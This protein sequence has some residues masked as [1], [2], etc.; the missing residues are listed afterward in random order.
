MKSELSK[1]IPPVRIDNVSKHF[2]KVTAVDKLTLDV[3]PG[4]VLAL[5]GANGSGKSTTFRLLL[6]IYQASSGEAYLLGTPSAKLNG[7]DFEQICYVSEGQKLPL[8]MTV[9]YFLGFCS[10]LYPSWDHDLCNRLVEAFGLPLQQK[11]KHLSRG[12]RMKA[13]VASTLPCRPKVL[14]LDEPFSG[15]DVE[16]R[17]Q[18]ASLLNRLAKD[19][20]LATVITTHDVE[21]VEPVA[22]RI[23]ILANG[24]L[25]INE[26]LDPF[27]GRHRRLT[28][29]GDSEVSLPKEFLERVK[30]TQ[31]LEGLQEFHTDQF[32]ASMESELNSAFPEALSVKAHPM[33]LREI[34][35]KKAVQL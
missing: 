23:A 11:I 30:T 31:T 32:D 9:E 24:R 25:Q 2:R 22:N 19:D 35:T 21:E 16:T 33:S 12:Q 14:L 13:L 27:L 18:L 4:D 15:L 10:Q 34:L 20:G 29:E 5:I 3:N 17:A 8:W 26:A 1:S 28:I 7:K 6:S